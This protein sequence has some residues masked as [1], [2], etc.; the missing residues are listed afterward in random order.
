MVSPAAV[1]NV[2]A[3]TSAAFTR[4]P[5]TNSIPAQHS[6]SFWESLRYINFPHWPVT[7][8][9]GKTHWGILGEGSTIIFVPLCHVPFFTCPNTC[10]ECRQPCCACLMPAHPKGNHHPHHLD[11]N[12]QITHPT[13]QYL[14]F[15]VPYSCR[16]R[17][18]LQKSWNIPSISRYPLLSAGRSYGAT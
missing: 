11:L 18:L 15:S 10:M 6:N 8:L 13:C 1:S 17:A 4:V 3:R 7:Q 14:Q 2:L 12:S 9:T 5:K 16:K